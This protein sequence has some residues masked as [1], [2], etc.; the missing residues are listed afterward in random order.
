MFFYFQYMY[1][2]D[3]PLGSLIFKLLTYKK[4]CLIWLYV[5]DCWC[6]S[7]PSQLIF[8]LQLLYMFPSYKHFLLQ[9]EL[10][11]GTILICNCKCKYL[12]WLLCI[13]DTKVDEKWV[14][15]NNSWLHPITNDNQV[16]FAII[17]CTIE[18]LNVKLFSCWCNY[19][20]K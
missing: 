18:L 2:C 17:I 6:D 10:D 12:W 13:L 11:F 1:C 4:S 9:M 5:Y 15:V 16:I 14:H 3:W 7:C 8:C 20:H 19:L